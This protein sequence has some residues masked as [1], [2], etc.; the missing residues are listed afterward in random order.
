MRYGDPTNP[1][2]YIMPSMS[3]SALV[4]GHEETGTAGWWDQVVQAFAFGFPAFSSKFAAL[5]NSSQVGYGEKYAIDL[6]QFHVICA[7]PLGSPYGT[8]SPLSSHH[9]STSV[10]SLLSPSDSPPPYTYRGSFPVITPA[11]QVL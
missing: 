4:A 2:V 5:L 6:N 9:Q 7:A 3:H 1:I 11:D 8:S 10:S